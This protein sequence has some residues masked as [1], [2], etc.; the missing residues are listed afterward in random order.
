MTTDNVIQFTPKPKPPEDPIFTIAI[1]KGDQNGFSWIVASADATTQ[2]DA[3]Q[4]SNYLGDMFFALNPRAQPPGI[5]ER[6]SAFTHRFNP[7][8]KGRQNDDRTQA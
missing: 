3:Q 2:P 1:Y 6:L 8:R 7:F 5:L 4:L